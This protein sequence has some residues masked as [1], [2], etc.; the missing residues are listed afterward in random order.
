MVKLNIDVI[1]LTPEEPSPEL[2][3]GKLE[4]DLVLRR[5]L[6][7]YKVVHD[8]TSMLRPGTDIVISGV[9]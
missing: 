7:G 6:K 4:A 2:A 9:V 8:R 3:D 1:L 5:Q